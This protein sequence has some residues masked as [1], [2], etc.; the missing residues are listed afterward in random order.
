MRERPRFLC[1]IIT[2]ILLKRMIQTTAKRKC[3]SQDHFYNSRSQPFKNFKQELQRVL[4][5][6]SSDNMCFYPGHTFNLLIIA[7]NYQSAQTVMSHCA[8]F[9]PKLP[10]KN[11]TRSDKSLFS[12]IPFLKFHFALRFLNCKSSLMTVYTKIVKLQLRFNTT[13]PQLLNYNSC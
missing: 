10:L 2:E 6:I 7:Y 13:N 1:G 9:D 12:F 8:H 3:R 4:R 11:C 5:D